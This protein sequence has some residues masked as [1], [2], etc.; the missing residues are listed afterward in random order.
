MDVGRPMPPR[1]GRRHSGWQ[2]GGGERQDR[3]DVLEWVVVRFA[4]VVD[5][6]IIS[7]VR[8]VDVDLALRTRRH[9]RQRGLTR[10][11]RC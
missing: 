5:D 10:R 6:D 8:L 9:H 4:G 1:A 11:R 3:D 2:E 7:T